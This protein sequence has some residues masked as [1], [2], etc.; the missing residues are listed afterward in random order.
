MPSSLAATQTASGS[1]L[2]HAVVA[3]AVAVAAAEGG[4]G[5]GGREEENSRSKSSSRSSNHLPSAHQVHRHCSLFTPRALKTFPVLILTTTPLEQT[6][7]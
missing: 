6:L 5:E 4:T 1:D 7:L 3:V 2:S